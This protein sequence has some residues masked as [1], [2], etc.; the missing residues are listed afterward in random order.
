MNLGNKSKSSIEEVK[1]FAQISPTAYQ[2]MRSKDFRV[3]RTQ[4]IM[5]DLTFSFLKIHL[6][7]KKANF[8]DQEVI[9]NLEIIGRKVT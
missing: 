9:F 3:K 4:P 2:I 5:N 7:E 1:P 8:S 6:N